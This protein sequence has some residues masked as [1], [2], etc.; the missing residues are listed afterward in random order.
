MH[1]Y[2]A[3]PEISLSD[4]II[5]IKDW[6]RYLSGKWV[7][8]VSV[9]FTFGLMGF[10]YATYKTPIYIANSTFV[11]EDSEGGSSGLGQYAG[12]ASM[13][14]L[15]IGGAGGI[16]QGDNIME[17]YKSRS[18]IERTLL[19]KCIVKGKQQLLID[20]YINFNKLREKWNEKSTL[21][22]ITFTT[23]KD[24]P[25][26]RVQDSIVTSIVTDINKRSL[27]VSK[28]D[29]KLSII[30]V[31]VKSKDE[32]FAKIFNDNIVRNVNDFYVQTKTKKSF[33]N[34][35]ILQHQTD[36]IRRTL[37]SAIS[38]VAS[39]I[40]ANPNANPARQI[41][42]AP[43][44]RRQV[45]VQANTAILSELVKNL[46]ISKVSLRKETPLIQLIDIP[47]FPLYKDKASRIASFIL[48][49]I[50][51]SFITVIFLMMKRLFLL[52]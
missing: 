5:K 43:S 33:E 13:V 49:S 2:D 35:W 47:V 42:R 36:S 40:D 25:F 30:K 39:A 45:D 4:I 20:Y 50:L 27:T 48:F 34:L 15:D 21:K 11:I 37:N 28:P 9:S 18:M 17:L 46:E 26:S 12:I 22:N 10:V 31:E 16:F 14:G 51:G 24:R 1:N 32:A 8:I 23:F 41:L 19:S 44:Q 29:K 6:V 52:K 7:I 38:G 3:K